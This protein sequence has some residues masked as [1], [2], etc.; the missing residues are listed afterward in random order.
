[1]LFLAKLNCLNS[2]GM[3]IGNARLEAETKEKLRA[4][5]GPMIGKSEDKPHHAQSSS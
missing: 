3:H 4:I 1:M 2:R 5:E